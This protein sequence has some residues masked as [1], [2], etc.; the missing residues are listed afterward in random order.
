MF[1]LFK[2][3]AR[4]IAI[5]AGIAGLFTWFV[6][7]QRSKGAKSAM[8]K[9]EKSNAKVAKA[10]DDAGRKSLDGAHGVRNRFYRD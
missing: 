5:A 2:P 4:V 8:T 6:V 9:V 10:A 7:E 1:D 3:F